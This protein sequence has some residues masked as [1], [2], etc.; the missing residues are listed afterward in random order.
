MGKK[1]VVKIHTSDPK[2]KYKSHKEPGGEFDIE[3][4]A[5]RGMCLDAYFSAYPYCLSLMYGAEFKFMPEP[6]TVTFQCPAPLRPVVME[7]RRIKIDEKNTKIVIT[8]KDILKLDN[9]CADTCKCQ[10]KIGEVFEFNHM[11]QRP[12]I[13]PAGFLHI[14]P[15]LSCLLRGGSLPWSTGKSSFLVHCPDEKINVTYEV[16]LKEAEDK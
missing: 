1:V 9:K 2:C 6:N 14:F 8:V 3:L 15:Y 5:P 12:E 16:S 13:C 11:G 4:L 10:M 7:A